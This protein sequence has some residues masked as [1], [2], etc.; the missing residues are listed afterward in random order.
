MQK[1]EDFQQR[2]REFADTDRARHSVL[3]FKTGKGE[4]GEGDIFLGATVPSTRKVCKEFAQ[5][6]LDEIQKLLDSAVHE[7]RLGA[8]I[9]LSEQYKKAKD[10]KTRQEL[11]EFYLKNV[12]AERVNNWDIVDS[13]AHK[14]LGEYLARKDKSVLFELA[15][16]DSIWQRRVAIIS[17][18]AFIDKGECSVS[19]ELA[20]L[21]LHDTHDLI[22]KAVGWV[23]REVG[24]QCDEAILHD[25]LDTHA[26][27]M[28]RTMLRYAIERLPESDRKSYLAMRNIK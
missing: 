28:P 6:G 8:V 1:A 12:R 19:L 21:L 26:H 14:I 13:S 24:K 9:I 5:L 27:D 17:T 22:H 18:F 20:E 16:S 7:C 15:R 23:L 10:D 11:Y 3:F 2:L 25:F 4:Y